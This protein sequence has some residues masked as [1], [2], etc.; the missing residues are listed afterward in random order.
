MHIL[1]LVD[2][3]WNSLLVYTWFDLVVVLKTNN[4]ILTDLRTG[5]SQSSFLCLVC[6]FVCLFVCL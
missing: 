5:L 6:L 2:E 1:R 3:A 4:T